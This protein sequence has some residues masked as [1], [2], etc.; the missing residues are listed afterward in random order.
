[1]G[2]KQL[3]Y[4]C[5]EQGV[6]S[7]DSEP[8][9]HGLGVA[10]PSLDFSLQLSTMSRGRVLKGES[11]AAGALRSHQGLNAGRAPP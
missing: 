2:S 10:H 6:N 7:L 3:A 11:N 4:R 9:S 1:M 5:R 8:H